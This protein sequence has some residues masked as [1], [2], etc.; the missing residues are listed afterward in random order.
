M[1]RANDTCGLLEALLSGRLRDDFISVLRRFCNDLSRVCSID[2]AFKTLL[3]ED[4]LRVADALP[5][6]REVL[7]KVISGVPLPATLGWVTR[8]LFGVKPSEDSG[9][10]VDHTVGVG[11]R[12]STDYVVMRKEGGVASW[13]CGPLIKTIEDSLNS[14]CLPEGLGKAESLRIISTYITESSGRRLLKLLTRLSADAVALLPGV[15]TYSTIAWVLRFTPL[16]V[17]RETLRDCGL[18][19]GL[20]DVLRRL[21]LALFD[22][23]TCRLYKGVNEAPP[24][25]LKRGD[26][27]IITSKLIVKRESYGEGTYRVFGEE[28]SSSPA[29]ALLDYLTS[30]WLRAE[31]ILFG[32]SPAT[33]ILE[34]YVKEM[35]RERPRPSRRA[36]EAIRATID[37]GVLKVTTVPG[38]DEFLDEDVSL[39]LELSGAVQAGILEASVGWDGVLRGNALINR[40]AVVFK[41]SYVIRLSSKLHDAVLQWVGG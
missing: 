20:R 22:L 23:R 24:K 26:Y 9:F 2:E 38:R 8:T 14:T 31:E 16:P 28:V 4:G 29:Y 1:G 21:S 18:S 30:G 33:S 3:G 32:R 34:R 36:C 40:Y 11:I 5:D 6:L 39:I 17:I 37:S 10:R 15:S 27:V 13:I 41:P 12:D 35:L 7:L 19:V 25:L